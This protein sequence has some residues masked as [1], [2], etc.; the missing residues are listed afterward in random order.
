MEG[1][2]PYVKDIH[3]ENI[4]FESVFTGLSY[5][6]VYHYCRG[7]LHSPFHDTDAFPYCR[8]NGTPLSGY[9]FRKVSI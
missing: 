6:T 5:M 1:L 8:N 3:F 7:E 9:P 2:C 4:S